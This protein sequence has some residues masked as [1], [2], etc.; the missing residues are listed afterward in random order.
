MAL[1]CSMLDGRRVWPK[2]LPKPPVRHRPSGGC[3][4]TKPSVTPTPPRCG[5]ST[6]HGDLLWCD[7]G[8][9]GSRHKHEL[10]ELSGTGAPGSAH[11]TQQGYNRC[12]ARLRALIEHLVDRPPLQAPGRCKLSRAIGFSPVAVMK[13]PRGWPREFPGGGHQV[14]PG[15]VSGTTPLPVMAWLSRTLSPWVVHRWAWCS[16]R[17]TVAVASVLGMSSS[18]PAGWRLLET[19]T[20]RRSSAAS[21]SRYRP[22]AASGRRAATRCRRPRPGRRAG[23]ARP[24]W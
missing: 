15:Q 6:G 4:P 20:L 13:A 7:G 11:Q 14:I 23:S 21:T 18:N 12:R 8:W 1:T 19:A 10:L 17:S 24:P 3:D 9:P 22:S 16:S 2:L 5:G